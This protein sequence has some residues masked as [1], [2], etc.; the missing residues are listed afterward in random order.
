MIFPPD[1]TLYVIRH[2]E[3]DWNKEGMLQGQ[4]D[5]PLNEQGE[6]DAHRS[7]DILSTLIDVYNPPPF[8][9]SPLMRAQQ[10]ARIIC[11]RLDQSLPV[12]STDVDLMELTFGRWE[13]MT[14]REITQRF[15]HD[16]SARQRDK[17]GYVPPEGENYDM[18]LTRVKR[19]GERIIEHLKVQKLNKSVI[20]AHGGVSRVLL[21]SLC[22]VAHPKAAL[23]HI[24]HDR[25]LIIADRAYRWV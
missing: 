17:W 3:T 1:T 18:L 22:G 24:P 15:P 7:G 16:A 2:G 6:K 10:T 19:A 11:E 9:V 23:M 13:G 5:I 25:V 4:R 12:I 20:V 21:A 14:W 8:F